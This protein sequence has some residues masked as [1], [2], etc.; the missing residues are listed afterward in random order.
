MAGTMKQVIVLNPIEEADNRRRIASDH[1]RSGS[2]GNCC[3]GNRIRLAGALGR[4][5]APTALNCPVSLGG[6]GRAGRDKDLGGV[7][8]GEQVGTGGAYQNSQGRWRTGPV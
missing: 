7:P 6:S 5:A 1:R 3:P 4:G 2:P 8:A